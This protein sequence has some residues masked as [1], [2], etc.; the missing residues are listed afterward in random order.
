MFLAAATS[1]CLRVW[2]P[3][4]AILFVLPSGCSAWLPAEPSS[5]PFPHD[6]SPSMLH[7]TVAAGLLPLLPAPLPNWYSPHSILLAL[8]IPNRERGKVLE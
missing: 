7:V 5:A 8:Q 1:C 4:C 2:S 6:A 3:V